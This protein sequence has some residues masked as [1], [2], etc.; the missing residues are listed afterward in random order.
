MTWPSLPTFSPVTAV[1]VTTLVIGVPELVMNCFVP[2]MTHSSPS[3]TAV[4]SVPAAS[5]PAFASVRPKP[6]SVRPA[7]R[8]G[9]QRFFCSSV[10]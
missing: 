8:S 5:E 2:L 10:P 7:S 1:M 9:S 6:A 3:R 4:V